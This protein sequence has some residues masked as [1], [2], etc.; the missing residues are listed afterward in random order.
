MDAT[1]RMTTFSTSS[2]LSDDAD[3]QTKLLALIGREPLGPL[4]RSR[5]RGSIR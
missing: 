1:A 2:C 4:R 5:A 3:V